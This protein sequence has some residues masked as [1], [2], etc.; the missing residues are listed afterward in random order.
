MREIHLRQSRFTYSACGQF[1]KKERKNTKMWG[2]RKFNIHFSN[3]LDKA[4]F[5]H[6]MSYE[7]FKDLPRRTV[8]N[9]VLGGKTFS[10]AKNPKHDG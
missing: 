10:I 5:Q 1:T 2:N 3:I 4:C 8:Y 6:V 7:D 9:K